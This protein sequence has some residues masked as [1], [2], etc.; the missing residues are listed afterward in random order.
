MF[1][2]AGNPPFSDSVS[3]NVAKIFLSMIGRY[4][5]EANNLHKIFN[6]NTIKVSYS[7][8]PNFSQTTWS[9]NKK[10]LQ[11]HH[12]KKTPTETTFNLGQK[13]N[14]PLKW[15]CLAKR[16]VYEA[17]VTETKTNKQKTL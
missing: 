3:T 14:C 16:I 17:I 10:S 1:F 5:P 11:Q 9:H 13:E 12:N 4:F 6:R 8:M 7:C 2:S 15:H